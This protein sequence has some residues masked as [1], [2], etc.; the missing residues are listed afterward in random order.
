[1]PGGNIHSSNHYRKHKKTAQNTAIPQ[2]R[3]CEERCPSVLLDLDVDEMA[4]EI[5]MRF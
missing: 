5:R 3:S 2:P 4:E 1:M